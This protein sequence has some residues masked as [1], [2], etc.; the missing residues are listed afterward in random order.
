[1]NHK[2]TTTRGLSRAARWGAPLAAVVLLA[3]AAFAGPYEDADRAFRARDYAAAARYARQGIE[4]SPNDV[5]LYTA[6]GAA[7]HKQ[8]DNAGAREAWDNVFRLDPN[9]RSIRDDAGFLRAYRSVGGTMAPGG[10]SGQRSASRSGG[11]SAEA[12]QIIRA[13]TEGDVYV[14]PDLAGQVDADAI[15]ATV[16]AARP[17]VVKVVAVPKLG[18]YPTPAA[19][20]DDLRKQLDLS[21]DA[22]VVVG[23]PRRLAAS[24]GRLSS[25]Q[26]DEALREAGLAQ[27]YAQGGLGDALAVAARAMGGQVRADQRGD[28]NRAGS[29]GLLALLAV[30]GGLA[31]VAA[32]RGRALADA[33]AP[34]EQ[35][36]QEALKNL[37]YVDG[38]LDLLP[39]GA[40]AERARALRAS[41]Y[42]KYATANALLNQSKDP[43][44]VRQAE[45][46]LRQALDELT[47]CRSEIDRATGGT[48]VAMSVPEI[49]TLETDADRVRRFK[50]AEQIK[51]REEADRL[52]REIDAL[53]EDQRGVSF[54][55]GQPLPKGQLVPVQLVIDGQKRTVMA[56]REEAEQIKRGQTPQVRAFD[57]GNGQYV[58]WYENRRYDPYRDYYGGWGMG[59]FGGGMGTFVNL[60]LLSQLFGGGLF[61]GYG[62]GYGAPVVI[63]NYPGGYGY[64]DNGGF[65][66]GGFF[67][68]ADPGP[69]YDPTPDHSGGFDFFGQQGY[70]DTSGDG[71]GFGDSGGADFGGGDFGGGDFGGGDW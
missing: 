21:G 9:L 53:P 5:R 8:G 52:Q 7:L 29:L 11:T 66:G 6:L 41:A 30:G 49:P 40:S 12:N 62:Y 18:P 34:G 19:M 2:R 65:G 71:F 57:D 64:G 17:T 16:Q 67:G 54:F 3:G 42:E 46:L 63:N 23:T 27:A 56:S 70:D 44:E 48:G 47:E 26:V 59:G 61:H 50:T 31:F 14:H 24:S 28:A 22:A 60:F 33:K 36:R 1:M 25:A 10:G 20:A 4:Q 38:Y 45:P 39:A 43:N 35:L 13:L 32:R 55:S 37:S 51:S 69:Q 15:R 58:P 68:G